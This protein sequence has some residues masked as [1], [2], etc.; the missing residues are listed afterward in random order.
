ML[1]A[2]GPGKI[3]DV[4][5]T[6][7]TFLDFHKGPEISHVANAAF[8]YGAH[9]VTIF[10]RGPGIR[11]E[12]LQAQRDAAILCVRVP[13]HRIHLISGA[14]AFGRMLHAPRPGHFGHVNQTFDARLELDESAIVGDID[15]AAY[16][17]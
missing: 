12:L 9:A 17:S 6:V 14:D 11:L 15:D 3:G 8:D 1:D 16:D 10:N 7:N 13:N 4:D 2:L 5:Q